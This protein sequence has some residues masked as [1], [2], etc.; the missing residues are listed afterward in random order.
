[1]SRIRL[2]YA[3]AERQHTGTGLLGSALI[4]AVLVTLNLS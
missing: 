1:M 4:V 2:Q 3:L